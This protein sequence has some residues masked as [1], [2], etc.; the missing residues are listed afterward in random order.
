[1]AWTVDI[2]GKKRLMAR[3]IKMRKALDPVAEAA[4]LTT[5]YEIKETA[6]ELCPVGTPDSTGIPGYIGGSLKQSG[7]IQRHARSRGQTLRVGVSFGG[8]ITNPNTGRK[9]D[10]ARYVH[11]GTSKMPGRPFLKQAYDKH[12]RNLP[13]RIKR[14]LR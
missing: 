13:R 5:A 1:M 14:G 12:R 11:A 8:Y 7:R 10:Y 2:V 6:Q 3:L 9:V 4:A